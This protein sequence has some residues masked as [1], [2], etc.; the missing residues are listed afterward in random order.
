LLESSGTRELDLKIPGIPVHINL[1]KFL[2]DKIESFLA[3]WLIIQ[4][5]SQADARLV[6]V[7]IVVE[8]MN[9]LTVLEKQH[10]ELCAVESLATVVPK[11]SEGVC[12]NLYGKPCRYPNV[13]CQFLKERKG[14]CNFNKK[15][16]R[17]TIEHLEKRGVIEKVNA[18]E[19][20][21]WR[22]TL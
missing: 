4:G 11:T 7:G 5:A 14:T 2:L 6:G 16:V 12:L 9:K 17:E 13:K 22:V 1:S 20:V 3:A 15:A 8:L 10:G 18:V 19:P 21:S